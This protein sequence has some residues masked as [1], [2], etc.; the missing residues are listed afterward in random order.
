MKSKKSEASR[1]KKALKKR[2]KRNEWVKA[3]NREMNSKTKEE[4]KQ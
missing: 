2:R 3:H 4:K 1:Q